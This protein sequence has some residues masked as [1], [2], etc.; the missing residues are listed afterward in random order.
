MGSLLEVL[1]LSQNRAKI[2]FI[3]ILINATK[4]KFLW[5][6]MSFALKVQFL[7]LTEFYLHNYV[8]YIIKKA[9]CQKLILI[10]V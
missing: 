8:G 1:P 4:T 7:F 10:G 6:L 5:A 2:H 9:I 3:K